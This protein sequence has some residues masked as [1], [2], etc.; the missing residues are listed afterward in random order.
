MGGPG[1]MFITANIGSLSDQPGE[2]QK[3]WFQEL[4]QTIHRCNP[5]FIALHL[6]EFGGKEYEKNMEA[7][8]KLIRML[9]ESQELSSYERVQAFIDTD[10]SQPE[11]FTALGSIYLIHKSL[12][13]IQIYNF[14]EKHFATFSGHN[15]F[16][17]SLGDC[18]LVQKERFPQDFWKEF[19]WTRKGFMRTRWQLHDR[20]FDLVN[21]H[22]FHDASNL[23]S[24]ELS[25]SIYSL[26]RSKAL[27]HVLNRLQDTE[28]VPFFLFG[29]FNFRLDLKSFILAESWTQK[30]M[31]EKGTVLYE[32]EGLVKL[33][34]QNKVFDH[35]NMEIF[36]ENN[37]QSLR[38]FDSEPLPFLSRLAEMPIFFPPSYPF[39][40]DIT[41]PSQ[42]MGTRCPSWCD[43][44]LMSYSA[45]ALLNK[46]KDEESDVQ[47]D[48]IGAD[49]CMGD[50]KPVFLYW[51]ME[52]PIE[53]HVK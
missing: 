27:N 4:F 11:R 13:R 7:A 31:T 44:V 48:R 52:L 8:E 37:V 24:L 14:K 25:P 38:K 16:L 9:I 15:L 12:N 42:F 47:Y 34:I 22:L 5:E 28:E 19:P 41:R 35:K 36:Q 49:V 20:T 3:N 26:N 50:H 39:S 2:M 30:E 10:Y 32:Q 51:E 46:V 40:E 53:N 43:R 23:I 29:D 17:G 1:V 6:Q 33:I 21:L 45:R 18:P